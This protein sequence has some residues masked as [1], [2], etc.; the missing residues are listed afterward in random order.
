MTKEKISKL[1]DVINLALKRGFFFPSCELYS[2]ASSGFF[3]YG[4]NGVALKNKIIGQWRKLLK[5]DD[6]LEIDGS[7]IMSKQVFQAS[8]H[9]TSFTDPLVKCEKCK[10]IYR[11]DKL[12]EEKQARQLRKN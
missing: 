6:A 8:G 7:Q 10:S 4:P 9:L 2:D 11:A 12:I 3:D 1:D 5:E